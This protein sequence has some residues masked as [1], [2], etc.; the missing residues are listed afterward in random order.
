MKM[1]IDHI[2]PL[3]KQAIEILRSVEPM[4]GH[5]KYV[6]PSIRTDDRCMSDNTINAALR[7][8]AIRRPS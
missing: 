8:R 4:T 2:V 1:K 5:G 7:G 3:A 6:F